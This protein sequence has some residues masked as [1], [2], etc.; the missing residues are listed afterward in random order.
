MPGPGV[1]SGG[2][3]CLWTPRGLEVGLVLAGDET[4]CEQPWG[5]TSL[6]GADRGTRPGEGEREGPPVTEAQAGPWFPAHAPV[7]PRITLPL[8][9]T[10]S[11][12]S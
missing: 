4:V 12:A 9:L 7:T 3:L 11:P 1:Q 6:S 10:V 5:L 8:S 2:Q